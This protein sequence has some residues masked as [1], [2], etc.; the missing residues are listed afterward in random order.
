MYQSIT[1][2][3]SNISTT[4]FS[5]IPN[6]ESTRRSPIRL[7][8][9]ILPS[10][11]ATLQFAVRNCR[12]LI[13]LMASFQ[14]SGRKPLLIN[15]GQVPVSSKL[16]DVNKKFAVTPIE[17]M[18]K[19]VV[20]RKKDTTSCRPSSKCMLKADSAAVG[21]S[22]VFVF[23]LA[24]ALFCEPVFAWIKVTLPLLARGVM[25]V[26]FCTTYNRTSCGGQS[27]GAKATVLYTSTFRFL[28]TEVVRTLKRHTCLEVCL[29]VE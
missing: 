7:N 17:I 1:D 29:A 14:A 12:D 10:M 2:V 15:L 18:T 8:N 24:S 28:Q 13:D 26:S 23:A 20:L 21:G 5:T 16:T 11:F 27:E 22:R 9:V 25:D 3:L 4:R 6:P 19:Y